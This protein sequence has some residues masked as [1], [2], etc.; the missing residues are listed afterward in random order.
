M[1][2]ATIAAIT[3]TAPAVLSADE[4]RNPFDTIRDEINRVDDEDMRVKRGQVSDG[5]MTLRVEDEKKTRGRSEI[6]GQD[7][8]I[9]VSDLDQSTETGTNRQA[10]EANRNT[11]SR[12]QTR[13]NALVDDVRD[14][15]AG[16]AAAVATASHQFDPSHDGLQLSL[17]AG[18]HE[19]E[20]AA[21]VALGGAISERVFINVNSS[22]TSRDQETYGAGMT[23]QF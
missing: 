2:Y 3:L 7:V 20:T 16:V 22:H 13:V 19:S 6:Y 14:L 12:Y 9:D 4:P 17:S 18:Y 11:L 10:I 21:S 5:V 23:V 8:E 15:R 1:K